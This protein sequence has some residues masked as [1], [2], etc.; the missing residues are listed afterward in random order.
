MIY[1][2]SGLV[3]FLSLGIIY[4]YIS[5]DILFK[6]LIIDYWGSVQN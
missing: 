6:S 5:G 1:I 2:L 3:F 4:L